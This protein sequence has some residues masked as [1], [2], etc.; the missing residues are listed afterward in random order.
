[1][2]TRHPYSSGI[3]AQLLSKDS[4]CRSPRKRR[5]KTPLWMRT[6]VRLAP[7]QALGPPLQP[8]FVQSK[9][10]RSSFDLGHRTGERRGLRERTF[11]LLL[12]KAQR[13]PEMSRGPPMCQ[14]ISNSIRAAA[15]E[16]CRSSVPLGA[17]LTTLS[18]WSDDDDSHHL[19][20]D[21]RFDEGRA[22]SF[23]HHVSPVPGAMPR[24][25]EALEKR[26]QNEWTL[27]LARHGNA[28][29]EWQFNK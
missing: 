18:K 5:G 4:W 16:S 23:F 10:H 14:A 7:S 15:K 28:I 13:F 2:K 29:T 3:S 11:C 19:L 9:A 21:Q 12:L 22:T 8:S 26:L 24:T 6:H 20:H 17:M 1:M 27:R 25:V